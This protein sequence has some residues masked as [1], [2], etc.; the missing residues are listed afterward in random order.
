MTRVPA[1]LAT[2]LLAREAE[3]SR[4]PELAVQPCTLRQWRARGHIGPG[5]GYRLDEV[6]AY[7]E[8]RRSPRRAVAA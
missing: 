1:A 6:I 5:P 3:V 7:I 4:R 2:L 8:Q